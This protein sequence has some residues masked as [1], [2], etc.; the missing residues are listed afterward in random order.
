M[1]AVEANR[2]EEGYNESPATTIWKQLSARPLHQV[3]T[4][5]PWVNQDQTGYWGDGALPLL[6]LAEDVVYIPLQADCQEQKTRQVIL[7]LPQ[8]AG[9]AL[10]LFTL[11]MSSHIPSSGLAAT[12]KHQSERKKG[13][14]QQDTPGNTYKTRIKETALRDVITEQKRSFCTT[15]F[16][17]PHKKF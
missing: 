11:V 4:S 12:G 3:F 10:A 16:S 15:N 1:W 8:P 13:H 7:V 9:L 6:V 14:L 17:G 5:I 2:E